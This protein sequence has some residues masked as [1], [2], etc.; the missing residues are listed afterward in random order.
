MKTLSEI[1]EEIFEIQ[2]Y[3]K[4]NM[5][6]LRYTEDEEYWDNKID[7]FRNYAT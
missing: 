5:G 3:L 7:L 1:K 4:E 6:N 2:K